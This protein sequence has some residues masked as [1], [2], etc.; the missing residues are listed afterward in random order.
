MLLVHQP[1]FPHEQ[2]LRACLL[3]GIVVGSRPGDGGPQIALAL[4]LP[5][6]PLQEL[7]RACA[8]IVHGPLVADPTD[9]EAVH[10]P[11]TG[12]ERAAQLAAVDG[13]G[14]VGAGEGEVEDRGDAMP[15]VMQ[16]TAH[17]QGIQVAGAQPGRFLS[18]ELV[19]PAFE[20]LVGRDPREGALPE[21]AMCRH[22][23]GEHPHAGGIH[24]P[25]FRRQVGTG[26][27]ANFKNAAIASHDQVSDE[28]RL[29]AIGHGEDQRVLD[30]EPRARQ[31]RRP[32][33]LPEQQDPCAQRHRQ[34]A[35]QSWHV[36]SASAEPAGH[37]AP[38]LHMA[39]L[40]KD[41][42]QCCDCLA[43]PGLRMPR[44]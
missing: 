27:G 29:L 34:A 2:R 26:T 39:N 9:V 12:V 38:I 14:L 36:H 18:I 22:K 40:L 7:G 42:V 25:G 32:S 19:D 11:Y 3:R 17:R 28:R 8:G 20:V 37:R 43:M 1:E 5:G 31:R 41:H 35:H 30:D 4:G 21:M 16:A 13:A 33:R 6:C 15:D 44:P 23:A 10:D 24:V